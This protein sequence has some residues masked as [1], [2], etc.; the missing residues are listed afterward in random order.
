MPVA[1]FVEHGSNLLEHP[2]CGFV[3]DSDFPLDLLGGNSTTGGSHQVDSIEPKPERGRGLVVN[4]VRRGVDMVPAEI[5]TVGRSA[6]NPMM[7]GHPVTV[8]AKD[9]IGIEMIPEPFQAGCVSGKYRIE[10]A[11]G[12]FLS[13]GLVLLC[14]D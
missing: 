4:G 2:P 13:R 12:E 6:C 11:D 10:M 3:S 7:F 8:L 14:H 5:A 9:A 1:I